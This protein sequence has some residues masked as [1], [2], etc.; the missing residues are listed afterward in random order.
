MAS[1]SERPPSFLVLGAGVIGLTTALSLRAAYP[2]SPITITATHFPGDRSINYASPWAGANWCTFARDNGRLEHYDRVTFHSFSEIVDKYGPAAG[3]ERKGMWGVFDSP[4]EEAGLL[5]EGTGKIWFDELVGGIRVLGENEGPED[6]VFGMEFMSFMIDTQR[7]L[8][9]LHAQT[10]ASNI[11]HIRRTYPSLSLL[12]S[13]FPST[14]LLLNCAG[15]GSYSLTDVADTTMYP[16]RGQT[17]LIAEPK[18]PLTRM[19]FRSTQR[20]CPEATYVFPRPYGGGVILGGSRQD[21]DWNAEVDMELADDIIKRCCKLAPELGKPEDLQIISH[22]VGLRPSRKGMIRI[23][24]EK[25]SNGIPV[26][27]N[28]GHAG[29]G[30]Q[31]SWGT[32]ERALELVKTALERKNTK[33]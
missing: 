11:T 28:Y 5:S 19:Y 23:E 14:T 10:I 22:N 21:G 26:I 2:E 4:L 9:W 30:Y 3:I 13:A 20:L 12:M 6:K 16:T 27:H 24:L 8:S 7:Y 1:L 32:A 15:L 29:A 18:V 25:W 17:V 31:S 33:L